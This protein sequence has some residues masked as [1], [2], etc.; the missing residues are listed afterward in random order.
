MFLGGIRYKE[1]KFQPI[2]ARVNAAS[3]NL[4]VIALLLPTAMNYTSQG[5]SERTLQNFSMAVAV[6]LIVVY[7]PIP[8]MPD[9]SKLFFGL[10]WV[11]Q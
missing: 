8:L 7:E 1:Q 4:A 6:V 9:C 10:S 2:V 3:I 5:I 11:Y